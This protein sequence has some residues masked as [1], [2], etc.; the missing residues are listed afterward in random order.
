M[1]APAT[2]RANASHRAWNG[3]GAPGDCPWAGGTPLLRRHR[4]PGQAY[5]IA[6][7][8]G[9]HPTG[10]APLPC[11][12]GEVWTLIRSELATVTPLR[13]PVTC[14]FHTGGSD[15]T[16]DIVERAR[17]PRCLKR[18]LNGPLGHPS[19]C[20]FRAERV[21]VK[22]DRGVH[23]EIPQS[24]IFERLDRDTRASGPCRRR[25]DI[26]GC[27]RTTPHARAGGPCHDQALRQ[28]RSA[29]R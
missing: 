29:R 6:R 23:S 11:S 1:H 25:R 17:H 5:L 21:I 28:S 15:S 10:A 24:S 14:I 18:P 26:S 19:K 20:R 16:V 13:I 4:R 22:P 2:R 27:H 12:H 9:P 7:P 8:S 3:D